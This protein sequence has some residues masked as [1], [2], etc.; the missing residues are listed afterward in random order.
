MLLLKSMRESVL[1]LKENQVKQ[2]EMLLLVGMSIKIQTKFQSQSNISFNTLIMFFNRMLAP[3][4][5]RKRKNSGD[6]LY[7]SEIPILNEQKD[8]KKL[9]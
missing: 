4:N 2:S 8:S 5:I 3:M 7:S 6:I 9:T 1:V